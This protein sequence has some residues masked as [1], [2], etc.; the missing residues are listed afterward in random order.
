[1]PALFPESAVCVRELCEAGGCA[2]IL[3]SR[4]KR[5]GPVSLPDERQGSVVRMS[6]R[7]ANL[8]QRVVGC[9][10]AALASAALLLSLCSC[11]SEQQKT[12]VT[13]SVWDYSVISSGFAQYINDLNPDYDIEWIVGDNSLDFYSY[14]AKNGSLPDVVLTR[15]FNRVSADA[16]GDSLYDLSGTEL[17]QNYPEKSLSQIT[18]ND[19]AVK[20]VPGASGFKGI[21]V[22]SYLFQ[23]YD[24]PVPT[25][26]ESFIQA[27]QA[28][29]EKGVRGFVAGMGDDEV[30]YEVMQGFADSSLVSKTED[31]WGQIIKRDKSGN[32]VSVEGS[33]F[34]DALSYASTLAE[35]K[36]IDPSDM[37]LSPEDAEKQFL[38]GQAAMMFLEDGQASVYGSQHNM[39]VRALPFFG[40]DSSWAFAEPVFVGMVSDVKTQGVSTTASDETIHAPAVQVLSSIMSTE[41]QD[42]YLGLIG[43]DKLVPT[44]KDERIDLPDALTSLAPCLESESVRTY[45]PSK[46]VSDAVG[47]TFQKVVSGALSA[48]DALEEVKSLLQARQTQDTKT[49]VSFGE[50]VSNLYDSAKGNV[51]ACSIAQA[52][53]AS[54]E[55]DVFAISAKTARCP[56][57]SGDK[58][59]TDL[60]YSVAPT[61]VYRAQ[62]TGAQLKEYLA[63]CVS[64]ARSA[65][66]LPI[67]SGIHLVVAHDG[68]SYRLTTATR[69][70]SSGPKEGGADTASA[71]EGR[72]TT[73]PIEDD[74]TIT[75]GFSCY[76]GEA[77][78]ASSRAYGF[79]RED[80]TLQSL[81][82]G[83][84]QDKK[85]SSLP[86]YQ[87]YLAFG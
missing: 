57:Y 2:H 78:Q 62:M 20:Y 1:M 56:L 80:G 9:A 3:E 74:E 24:I 27:C 64:S 58:T 22:N 40:D 38:E 48:D 77:L 8:F 51:A 50:G 79:A 59:A 7:R 25:D 44:S 32:T 53:S 72:E 63:A 85:I 84:F 65:Y 67:V 4:E 6:G 34:D 86:A 69:I 21:V 76:D 42:Y 60:A 82:V 37:S 13:V 23:I 49:L 73:R 29:S 15:D 70:V 45:L 16:L 5:A 61:S 11:D 75:V 10:V 28:F 43:T 83:A 46:L 14:Q 18:G 55:T 52:A 54:L 81:W 39:T 66:D 87:D 68:D 41:A 12:H 19:G 36:V 33:S 31:L 35:Q 17:A 30:C 26:K 71:N 47:T